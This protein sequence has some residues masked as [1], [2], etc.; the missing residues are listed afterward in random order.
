MAGLFYAIVGVQGVPNLWMTADNG[1]TWT[2]AAD[3]L[4]RT[5]WFGSVHPLTGDVLLDSSMGRHIL[6]PPKGYPNVPYK[7]T[8]SA[9]LEVV[10][11]PVRQAS[12]VLKAAGDDATCAVS[13]LDGR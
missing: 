11:R 12:R 2:N 1:L 8:L 3:N 13:L 6:P 4:P 7:G 9:Q 5:L 10:L